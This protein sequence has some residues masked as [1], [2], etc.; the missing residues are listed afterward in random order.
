[1]GAIAIL[2]IMP[3]PRIVD[4]DV[5]GNFKADRQNAIFFLVKIV[6]APGDDAA[7]LSAGDIDPQFTELIQQ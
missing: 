5:F 6:F 4:I 7:Q 3:G 2:A 1:M